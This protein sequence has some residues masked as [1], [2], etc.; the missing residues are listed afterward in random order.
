MGKMSEEIFVR[1]EA[2][3][4]APIVDDSEDDTYLVHAELTRR[5]LPVDYR[6][7]DCALDM[8]AALAAEEW[9]IILADHHMP[10]FDAFAALDV[11]KRSGKDVPFII[12]SGQISDRQAVSAMYEGVTISSPRATTNACCR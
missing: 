7:V 5:G 1:S 11:L 9:D 4:R 6:R 3:V 10:G 2:P 8:A 12:H